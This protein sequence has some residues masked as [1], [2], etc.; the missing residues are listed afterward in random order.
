MMEMFQA[1]R[2]LNRNGMTI[3][4]IKQNAAVALKFAHRGYVLDT[5]RIAAQG[6]AASLRDNPGVKEA[7]LGG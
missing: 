4:P 2:E 5:G 6:E 1:L 3:L 7:Y